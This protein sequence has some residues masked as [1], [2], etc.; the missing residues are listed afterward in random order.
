MDLSLPNLDRFGKRS[1]HRA[2][3][4]F[5]AERPKKQRQELFGFHRSIGLGRGL[6][7]ASL[8]LVYLYYY[9]GGYRSLFLIAFIPAAPVILTLLLRI[10]RPLASG[11]QDSGLLRSDKTHFFIIREYWSQAGGI[12]SEIGEGPTFLCI[13]HSSDVSFY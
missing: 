9:P 12:V 7:L 8:A 6:P 2:R 1:P 3:D 11:P 10:N 13:D 5:F 4:A